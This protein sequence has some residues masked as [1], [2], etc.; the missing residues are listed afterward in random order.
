MRSRSAVSS[1]LVALLA[2]A[3]VAALATGCG[4][5]R[6]AV[7]PEPPR[8]L[9]ARAET[10]AKASAQGGERVGDTLRGVAHHSDAFTDW[11]VQLEAGQCYWFGY[12]GDA[13]VEKFSMYIWDPKDK[14]LDSARGKPPQGVFTHCAEQSG[15]YRVQGKVADGAGHYAVVVYKTKGPEKKPEPVA[16][17]PEKHDVDLAPIIE[18]KATQSAPGAK[19]SG[20]F[21]DG[22]AETSEFY[23]AMEA[24]KCYWIIGAGEPGKVKRLYLYLWDPKSKRVTENKSDSDTTMVGHCA[25]ESGMYKYQLK[26]DS[27]SGIYKAAIYVK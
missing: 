11:R 26:V 22:S 17:A 20:D 12:A 25:K 13:G 21:V 4:R 23:T 7:S 9:E 14:R 10:E 19:R 15:I 24:G 27:G 5:E 3:P 8:D 2:L 18:K 6:I 16:K 1:S